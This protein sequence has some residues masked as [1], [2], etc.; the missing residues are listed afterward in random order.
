MPRATRSLL[1]L[2]PFL[3]AVA[4]VSAAGSRFRPGDWYAALSLPAW[5]PPAWVFPVAW[6]LLY[7]A[8]A[9]AG[10]LLWRLPRRGGAAGRALWSVQLLL[11]GLWS[12]LFF[13]QHWIGVALL[14]LGALVATVALLVVWAW[15]R[16]R[17]AAWLLLPYLAWL[18][19]AKSLNAAIL[20]LNPG[21]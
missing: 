9:V 5:T 18:L 10:W 17:P 14:D 4:A 12:W 1:G 8:I 21:A 20:L 19:Y 2:V 3:L 7:L 13:G 15:P 16:C 6:T 11:N